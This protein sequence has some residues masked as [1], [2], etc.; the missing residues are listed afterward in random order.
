M[1]RGLGI[2]FKACLLFLKKFIGDL[3]FDALGLF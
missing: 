3:F 1:P 2:S